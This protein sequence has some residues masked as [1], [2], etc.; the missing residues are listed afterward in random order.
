[1]SQKSAAARLSRARRL[2]LKVAALAA[3][4]AL[5]AVLI[6]TLPAPMDAHGDLPDYARNDARVMEAYH[7][8]KSD[9]GWILD[10]M[11][12]YCG[13]GQHTGHDSNLACFVKG[14]GS[15]YDPHGAN[16]QVCVDIALSAKSM[17]AAG[18]PLK[19]IRTTIDARYPG[20]PATPTPMPP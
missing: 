5:A 19:E 8:A 4:P 18:T 1:M 2:A 11:A 17:Y 7:F 6:V 13:C 20:Y 14:D 9:Q 3:L 15:G 16:C 10:S 12:C